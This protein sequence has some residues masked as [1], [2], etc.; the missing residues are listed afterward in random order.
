MLSVL[1]RCCPLLGFK[2]MGFWA[3]GFPRAGRQRLLCQPHIHTPSTGILFL[4]S[5]SWPCPRPP[6]HILSSSCKSHPCL[7]SAGG[8]KCTFTS[9][10]QFPHLSCEA[11]R[12]AVRAGDSALSL[13]TEHDQNGVSQYS[14]VILPGPSLTLIKDTRRP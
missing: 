11:H 10:S 6:G 5:S 12:P 2:G 4:G 1:G 8:C 13:T 3:S 7:L 9:P 14:R